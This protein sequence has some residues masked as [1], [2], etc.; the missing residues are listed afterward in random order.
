M[1]PSTNDTSAKN[2]GRMYIGWS[3]IARQDLV[4]NP[5]CPVFQPRQFAAEGSQP[6]EESTQKGKAPEELTNSYLYIFG[7]GRQV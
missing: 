4:V 1:R 2:F 3:V 5:L 6:L 7:R